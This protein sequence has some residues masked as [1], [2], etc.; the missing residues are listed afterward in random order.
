MHV[1]LQ[2]EMA[3]Q[4]QDR[5]VTRGGR[6]I[7]AP[8][9]FGIEKDRGENDGNED[10]NISDSLLQRVSTPEGSLTASTPN[11]SPVGT[12]MITPLS[13]PNTSPD[14]SMISG[15]QPWELSP[16]KAPG[17]TKKQRQENVMERHR[18]LSDPGPGV[19]LR[20]PAFIHWDPGRP[21]GGD[22]AQEL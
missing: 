20:H 9:W 18:H 16:N 1:V 12:P 8:S 11:L 14:I 22:T 15:R 17:R 13:T 5:R 10:L 4:I 21:G 7:K 2:E 19:R 3:A 6:T